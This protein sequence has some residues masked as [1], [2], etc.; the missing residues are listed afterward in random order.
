MNLILIANWT[1]VLCSV[2]N[3]VHYILSYLPAGSVVIRIC[4]LFERIRGRPYCL[5][6]GHGSLKITILV[7]SSKT[8]REECIAEDFNANTVAV[9]GSG[10]VC[11]TVVTPL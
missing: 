6:D 9:T 2:V 10:R 7:F 11:G 4:A 3:Y 5:Q 8:Y 1:P